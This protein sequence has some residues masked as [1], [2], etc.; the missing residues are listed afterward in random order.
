MD[1]GLSE[2]LLSSSRAEP[3]NAYARIT[4]TALGLVAV[5]GI[6]MLS[7]NAFRFEAQSLAPAPAEVKHLTESDLS[8]NPL[9]EFVA[10]SSKRGACHANGSP[11]G[12]PIPWAMAL[13]VSPNDGAAASLRSIGIQGVTNEAIYF[14]CRG[15]PGGAAGP[16]PGLKEYNA[17]MMHIAG[18]YPGAHFEEQ[19]RAEGTVREVP[20]SSLG[21]HGLPPPERGL[22]VQMVASSVFTIKRAEANSGSLAPFAAGGRLALSDAA[23]HDA[24]LLA[25]A[26]T[27]VQAQDKTSDELQL[28][29]IR[30]GMR[31]YSLTPHRMEVLNGG[32]QWP[33]GPLRFEW[34]R[35]GDGGESWATPKRILP[36]NWPIVE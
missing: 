32:P 21:A 35:E 23:G 17:S 30:A 6:G 13:A 34:Q 26:V 29:A 4:C 36:Y 9:Q 19:W 10:R 15:G 18:N 5:L 8:S 24:H 33:S 14:V 27:H 1:A 25:D 7:S 16:P 3:H 2:A 31:V 11:K 20:L 22:L 12:F 28:D